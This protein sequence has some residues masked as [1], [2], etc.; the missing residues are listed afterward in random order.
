[1]KETREDMDYLWELKRGDTD[2]GECYRLVPQLN[3]C[4]S[5]YTLFAF[6][7][8]VPSHTSD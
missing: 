3:N 6:R 2:P 1:M 4:V 7:L 8:V 5:R